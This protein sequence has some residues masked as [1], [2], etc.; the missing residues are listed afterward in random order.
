MQGYAEPSGLYPPIHGSSNAP[1]AMDPAAPVP[2]VIWR[3]LLGS[4]SDDRSSG[5]EVDTTG[6]ADLNPAMPSV[7]NWDILLNS[8]DSTF[9]LGQ[10]PLAG[11]SGM[12]GKAN[13]D[14]LA[15]AICQYST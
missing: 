7:S 11:D 1:A 10:Y 5:A 12:P 4:D 6:G 14:S 15:T 8:T 2:S 3:T 13:T 9:G